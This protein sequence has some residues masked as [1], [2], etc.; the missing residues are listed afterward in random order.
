MAIQLVGADN[1][2][3]L[4][5]DSATGGMKT[6]ATLPPS[7]FFKANSAASTNAQVLKASPGK[8]FKI[9]VVNNTGTLAYVKLYDIATT[10]VVGTTIP[11][12][13]IG[14]HA[15]EMKVIDFDDGLPFTS[16]IA[17]AM[18]AL[19]ADSDSTAVPAGALKVIIRYDV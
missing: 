6:V 14:V 16:G 5:L 10:P 8:V 12:L 2:T 15:N 19:G 17:L 1:T 9:V 4:A 13:P 3:L 18:T 7:T 11:V